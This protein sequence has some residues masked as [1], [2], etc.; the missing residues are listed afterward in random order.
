MRGKGGDL[1]AY[2]RLFGLFEKKPGHVNKCV[3][4]VTLRVSC[5]VNVF[6]GSRK[7]RSSYGHHL[8]SCWL[9]SGKACAM[10]E[11][12]AKRASRATSQTNDSHTV[13]LSLLADN[14]PGNSSAD[15]AR[16]IRPPL[17][18]AQ[19]LR[20]GSTITP[21]LANVQAGNAVNPAMFVARAPMIQ[22][23]QW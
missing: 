10:A 9:P 5:L 16:V 7:S 4:K 13:E 17:P 23:A 18:I 8:R 2:E 20:T 6:T 14:A 3:Y 21:Q 11:P 1:A 19:G 12:Q 22:S 15:R